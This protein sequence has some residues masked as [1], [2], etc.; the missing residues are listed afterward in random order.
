MLCLTCMSTV[1]WLVHTARN[2]ER[3]WDPDWERGEWVTI[4]YAVLFTLHRGQERE[5]E[6]EN[7]Q[8]VLD[9]FFRT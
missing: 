5:W 6:R 9:P 8:W 2:R 4:Y 3:D 7:G 1:L